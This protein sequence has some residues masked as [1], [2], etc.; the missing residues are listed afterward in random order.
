MFPF[1]IARCILIINVSVK[2]LEDAFSVGALN[3]PLEIFV[4]CTCHMV[5]TA[6]E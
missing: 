1:S 3:N 5:E 2:R 6:M 4:L